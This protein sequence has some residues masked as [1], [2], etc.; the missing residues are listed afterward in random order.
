MF[1][2]TFGNQADYGKGIMYA[3]RMKYLTGDANSTGKPRRCEPVREDVVKP[4]SYLMT[5]KQAR[6]ELMIRKTE[7]LSASVYQLP[8]KACQ[9]ASSRELLDHA[10]ILESKSRRAEAG[11]RKSKNQRQNERRKQKWNHRGSACE[12]LDGSDIAEA[13]KNGEGKNK[14]EQKREL[15][16]RPPLGPNDTAGDTGSLMSETVNSVDEEDQIHEKFGDGSWELCEQAGTKFWFHPL[17]GDAKPYER[18]ESDEAEEV[19]DLEDGPD[20]FSFLDDFVG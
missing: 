13:K 3:S 4:P 10:A 9:T 20:S 8:Y 18:Y 11:H 12:N 14:Q 19:D 16:K 5:R 15:K 2:D 1:G 7:H 17:T 6:K